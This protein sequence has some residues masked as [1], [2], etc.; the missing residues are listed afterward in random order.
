MYRNKLSFI[1]PCYGSEKTITDVI[2]EIIE[3]VQNKNSY[4]IICVND[5]SPDNV[6]FVLKELA[7]N[8][9]SIKIIDLAKNS[10]KHAAVMAGLNYCSGDIIINLDDDGQCPTYRVYELI[11]ALQEGYDIATAYYGINN[12]SNF[13]NFGSKLNNMM[14]NCL[15]GKPKNIEITNFSVLKRF[16]VEE[17][18]K[19][20]NPYPYIQGLLLNTTLRIKNIK[21]EN[22]DRFEGSSNF[23]FQ[24]MLSLWLNGFTAFSVKPLRV[25]TIVGFICSIVGFIYGIWTILN[26]IFINSNAPLGYSSTMAAMMFIGGIIMLMLGIIGEYIGRIYISINNSP[27]YVIREKINYEMKDKV[28]NIYKQD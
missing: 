4:E 9:N 27:Q 23:N 1:I 7:I 19:Y 2:N 6:L 11:E 26:K 16:V 10:G 5:C 28:E 15:I 20:K 18:I 12:Q 22:R 13:K 21:M 14:L 8:N 17:I 3:T 24:K 25:A